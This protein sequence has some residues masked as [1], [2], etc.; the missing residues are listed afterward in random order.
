MNENTFVAVGRI[1]RIVTGERALTLVIG[2][3]GPIKALVAVQ[4][5]DLALIK[6]VTNQVSGFAPGDVVSAAGRLEYDCETHQNVAIASPD[7]VSR[8]ARGSGSVPATVAAGAPP[9]GAGAALFG[10]RERPAARAATEAD[11]PAPPSNM[12][13]PTHLD[14]ELVGLGDVQ[15]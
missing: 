11:A 15:L 3:T 2:G 13:F 9:T 7:R 14:G 5:R 1:E 12:S 4:L 6:L 10:R 8:I